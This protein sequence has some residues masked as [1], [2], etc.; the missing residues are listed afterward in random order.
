MALINQNENDLPI[1]DETGYKGNVDMI[2]NAKLNDMSS[3]RKDLKRYNLDLIEG[4][5]VI[6]MLVIRDKK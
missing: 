4:E 1:I 5:R 6:N 2:I 3:L